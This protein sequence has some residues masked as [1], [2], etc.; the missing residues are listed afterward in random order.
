MNVNE[1]PS[2]TSSSGDPPRLDANGVYLPA[3]RA[4]A[5]QNYVVVEVVAKRNR[6][7]CMCTPWNITSTAS[8]SSPHCYSVKMEGDARDQPRAL[9]TEI[10]LEPIPSKSYWAESPWG[11]CRLPGGSSCGKGIRFRSFAC[12]GVFDDGGGSGVSYKLSSNSSCSHFVLP[13]HTEVCEIPCLKISS[14]DDNEIYIPPEGCKCKKHTSGLLEIKAKC[15]TDS[16]KPW[17]YVKDRQTCPKHLQNV[18]GGNTPKWVYCESQVDIGIISDHGCDCVASW[19]DS[20]N[21]RTCPKEAGGCCAFDSFGELQPPLCRTVSSE[22]CSTY[23]PCTPERYVVTQAGVCSDI[24]CSR[25]TDIDVCTDAATILLGTAISPTKMSSKHVVSGCHVDSIENTIRLNTDTTASADPEFWAIC[26]CKSQPS[27]FLYSWTSGEWSP[28]E[29]TCGRVDSGV[30]YTIPKCVARTIFHG[31]ESD[32]EDSACASKAR[33][34]VESQNCTPPAE[35]CSGPKFMSRWRLESSRSNWVLAEVHLFTDTMCTQSVLTVEVPEILRV[36]SDGTTQKISQERLYDFSITT[37]VTF[38]Q[39]NV[40]FRFSDGV[41]VNCVKVFDANYADETTSVVASYWNGQN[42]QAARKFLDV[43]PQRWTYLNAN[44]GRMTTPN[45]SGVKTNEGCFC[46]VDWKIAGKNQVCGGESS[47]CCN[48]DSDAYGPSCPI[49]VEGSCNPKAQSD[50]TKSLQSST[51]SI[52]LREGFLRCDPPGL[53]LIQDA[54]CSSYGCRDIEAGDCLNVAKM[55]FGLPTQQA[56]LDQSF[57]G[58]HCMWNA[59]S[60][61][62]AWAGSKSQLASKGCSPDHCQDYYKLC[63]CSS[64]RNEWQAASWSACSAVCGTGFKSRSASCYSIDDSLGKSMLVHES[65]CDARAKPTMSTSCNQQSCYLVHQQVNCNAHF[66]DFVDEENGVWQQYSHDFGEKDE[67]INCRLFDADSSR[68]ETAIISQCTE[69]CDMLDSCVGVSI[70]EKREWSWHYGSGFRLEQKKRC[71]FRSAVSGW[72]PTEGTDCHMKKGVA[73]AAETDICHCQA[74]WRDSYS[75]QICGLDSGGCCNFGFAG[76]NSFTCPTFGKDTH[77]GICNLN[78]TKRLCKPPGIQLRVWSSRNNCTSIS[79]Q[80]LIGDHC[81]A[82]FS[83]FGL[84]HNNILVEYNNGCKI[85]SSGNSYMRL[86]N[87]PT[88]ASFYFWQSE[89]WGDFCVHIPGSEGCGE[90]M[91]TRIVS[92]VSQPNSG[93]PKKVTDSYCPSMA[94][95]ASYQNCTLETD[96]IQE[97][98]VVKASW[99]IDADYDAAFPTESAKVTFINDTKNSFADAMNVAARRIVNMTVKSGSIVVD[100]AITPVAGGSS[101]VAAVNSL[102]Q[103]LSLYSPY[104]WPDSM[105]KHVENTKSIHSTAY[106]YVV[107]CNNW[108]FA[109]RRR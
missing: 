81:K 93:P 63:V 31:W 12:H 29:G 6:A 40:E 91:Q 107:G 66:A 20:S 5:I 46:R 74:G 61:S 79:C 4:K 16:G 67:Y 23:E 57:V 51:S 27:Q 94:K 45:D 21:K 25:I 65:L 35:T 70:S 7:S 58:S 103:K 109:R 78:G 13:S 92:C 56:S 44:W 37:K 108:S 10:T 1:V 102:K 33:P 97:E 50:V 90:G 96:C 82:A 42:W 80:E 69:L 55:K 88:S 72:T 9:F 47:G 59:D 49:F 64:L 105:K 8:S 41:S 22:S 48:V 87:C 15:Q 39:T 18:A 89:P 24:G 62:V 106:G 30:R 101:T 95:P 52:S 98:A 28:C 17:C 68:D 26:S 85:N 43:S 53:R 2:S 76:Q 11:S 34:A 73:L 38:Y 3:S 83:K 32:A 100:F 84:S 36:Y 99:T 54:V 104:I 75:S 71:C 77:T 60:K 14:D 19:S 86:C